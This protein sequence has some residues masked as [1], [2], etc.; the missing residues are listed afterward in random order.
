MDQ[1]ALGPEVAQALARKVENAVLAGNEL[2]SFSDREPGLAA[3]CGVEISALEAKSILGSGAPER[4]FEA[5]T[6]G[7]SSGRPFLVYRADLDGMTRLE[8]VVSLASSR[9]AQTYMALEAADSAPARLGSVV[10]T[11]GAIVGL[12]RSFF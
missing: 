12:V 8:G 2:S 4:L 1:V 11:I 6:L 3:E 10:G 5:A 9:I 7:A